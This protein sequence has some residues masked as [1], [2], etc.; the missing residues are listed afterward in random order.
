MHPMFLYWYAGA[1]A[2]L[3]FIH[4]AP[5]LA[6]ALL[7]CALGLIGARCGGGSQAPQARVDMP[8][9]VLDGPAAGVAI[10][11]TEAFGDPGVCGVR[12]DVRYDSDGVAV[13]PEDPDVSLTTLPI[14]LGGCLPGVGTPVDNGD[15]TATVLVDV[16]CESDVFADPSVLPSPKFFSVGPPGTFRVRVENVVATD[17][18]AGESAGH[19][20][21]G[22]AVV[23]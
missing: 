11:Y 22:W 3:R 12:F 16:S 14:G 7:V 13:V 20:L 4:V 18:N 2:G 1:A 6:L 10:L 23:S 15:G 8:D 17:C 5:L 19:G 9:F 21:G